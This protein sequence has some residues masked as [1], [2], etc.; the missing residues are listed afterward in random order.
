MATKPYLEITDGTLS[1]IFADGSGGA[2]VFQFAYGGWAPAVAAPR[3]S[4]LGGLG[5]YEDVIEEIVVN[6]TGASVDAVL[7]NVQ[8]LMAL[9]ENAER[10]RNGENVTGVLVKY[11]PGGSTVSS[12]AAPMTAV[13]LGRAP[14][15]TSPVLNLPGTF[16]S[17]QLATSR[18]VLGIRLRFLRRGEWLHAAEAKTASSVTNGDIATLQT[19]TALKTLSPCDVAL[20]SV[21]GY[22][23][24]PAG[25]LIVADGDAS[26]AN[27]AI[28]VFNAEG[29]TATNYT[30][31]NEAARQARNTNVLR[32][33][34][35][36]TIEHNSAGGALTGAALNG[37]GQFAIFAN[38]R[39]NSTTTSF[40]LRAGINFV[41]S[42]RQYTQALVIPKQAAAYPYWVLLG[43][44]SGRDAR[45]IVLLTTGSAASGSLD[46]DSLVLVNLSERVAIAQIAFDRIGTLNLKHV[47]NV[48]T[49]SAKTIYMTDTTP[50]DVD[51][52]YSG[53]RAPFGRST[54]MYGVLLG[55][56]DSGTLSANQWRQNDGTPY[57]NNWTITRT[58]GYL[59]PA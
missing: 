12:A 20:T 54:K 46:I 10:W 36:D 33:T 32:Y 8:T 43:M 56:G 22:P 35:P 45:S 5:P 42:R 18:Y 38:V 6:V 37:S 40:K 49:P 58:A 4:Q 25:Y 17:K 21:D 50:L 24:F 41:G 23:T 39:N 44:V 53:D 59:V 30:A 28:E 7:A 57:A 11:S 47:L 15:D 14:G 16:E 52:T 29:L 31:V 9:I 34:P 51:Q 48:T 13:V 26:G 55:T 3:R 1:A 19:F 27:K 2:T